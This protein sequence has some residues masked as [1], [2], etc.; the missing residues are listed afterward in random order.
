MPLTPGQVAIARLLGSHRRPDS[1]LAG[2][3]ALHFAPNTKRYSNDLDFFHDTEE[4]VASA[5]QEDREAL[6]EAAYEVEVEIHQPGYIRAI[7]SKG[8][9]STKIEW[10][11]DSAWRFMP[12]IQVPTIGFQLHPVD[13]AVNK[14]L[15]LAGRDEARD[16][17]DVLHVDGEILPLGALVWAAVGKDPGF[18]P[19][20][21]LELI[22]RRGKYHPEDFSR[23]WLAEPVDLVELKG[24]WLGALERADEF[25]HSRPAKELGCLY[26]SPAEKRFVAP[27]PG[28]IVTEDPGDDP[29]ARSVVPHHG[30][31]GG[32]LPQFFGGDIL[33]EN[34]SR[35]KRIE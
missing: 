30:R 21:L 11:H 26:Y 13:L 2:G 9:E 8:E 15:A 29:D 35:L 4:R 24:R 34:L 28:T 16:F 31:P 10:A 14:V 32:V 19:F 17:Y 27:T 23:L 22:K 5:F 12:P 20:S 6:E 7:V 3:A 25:I 33:A 18:T 1:Y